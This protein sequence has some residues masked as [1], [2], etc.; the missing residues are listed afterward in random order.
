MA[1]L[2]GIA[3][4]GIAILGWSALVSMLFGMVLGPVL[5][6]LAKPT[7]EAPLD[8]A[9][10]SKPAIPTPPLSQQE[11]PKGPTL[12]DCARDGDP[13]AQYVVGCNLLN[14]S[15]RRQEGIE[16]LRKATLQGFPHAPYELGKAL[17][18]YVHTPDGIAEAL[19]VLQDA[20]VKGDGKT[21]FLLFKIYQDGTGVEKN[22]AKA[23]EWLARAPKHVH[24]QVTHD[25]FILH[26]N[27]TVRNLSSK[28]RN[29]KPQA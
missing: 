14:D 21:A 7:F 1:L 3:A 24:R 28:L 2:L 10:L 20:A 17:F 11:E 23:E 9:N 6:R 12:A 19:S 4:G 26:T 8:I 27:L 18:A 25:H 15:V 5:A 13:E 22:I 16:F 29:E